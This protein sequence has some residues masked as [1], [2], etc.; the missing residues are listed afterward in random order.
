MH[1]CQVRF[2]VI[3]GQ[4]CVLYGGSE[5]SRDTDLVILPERKNLDSL[6]KALSELHAIPIAVPELS[7]ENLQRGHAVHFRCNHPDALDIRIDIMSVL[8]NAPPFEILWER[9]T[10][11]ELDNDITTEIVSLHDL[12]AIKKTQRDKDWSHIR[13]LIEAD[14]MERQDNP[15]LRDIQFWLA[16]ARTPAIIRTLAAGFP[17]AAESLSL[18]RHLLKLLPACSDDQLINALS[19]EEKLFREADRLYWQPLFKELELFRHSR[20]KT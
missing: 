3:G 1:G 16:E 11:I 9:R 14:F 20:K 8:H 18:K 19:E 12:V 10:T 17:D 13:R 4:A 7:L 15:S 6:R 2:L 5:F